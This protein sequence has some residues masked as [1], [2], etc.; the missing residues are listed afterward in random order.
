MAKPISKKLNPPSR[1]VSTQHAT[2][3]FSQLVQSN[4]A[5]WTIAVITF[6]GTILRAQLLQTP[7]HADELD[8]FLH[9]YPRGWLFTICVYYA[10]NNHIAYNLI[11][12]ALGSIFGPE[13]WVARL[14]AFVCGCLL[15]PL[16]ARVVRPLAGIRPAIYVS[17]LIAI[18]PLFINYSIYAR[19]YSLFMLLIVASIGQLHRLLQRPSRWTA[20]YLGVLW[21]MAAWTIPIAIHAV[22]FLLLCAIV[23]LLKKSTE[24]RRRLIRELTMTCVVTG[25]LTLLLYTPVLLVTGWRSLVADPATAPRAFGQLPNQAVEQ[26]SD[27]AW[28]FHRDLGPVGLATPLFLAIAGAVLARRQS[29]QI[30]A[31]AVCAIAAQIGWLIVQ[32]VCPF[33]RALMPLLWVLTALSAV[34]IAEIELRIR[35]ALRRTHPRETRTFAIAAVVLSSLII[36][37]S[38][39]KA[40]IN[41]D[42]PHDFHRV[43]QAVGNGQQHPRLFTNYADVGINYYLMKLQI[44]TLINQFK[45]PGEYLFLCRK[46]TEGLDLVSRTTPGLTPLLEIWRSRGGPPVNAAQFQEIGETPYYTLHR[47][48]LTQ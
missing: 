30:V 16:T 48:N 43:A 37:F 44:P 47:L 29:K 31:L 4:R 21:A 26:L 17:A 19:G 5:V 34:G 32:R 36:L 33:P 7:V 10:A 22:S 8:F 25:V 27:L 46:G 18:S 28:I 42:W 14:P 39:Q 11:L 23:Q 2:I 6:L 38:R 35:R 9:H 3:P 12:Q 41:G 20:I 24:T 45:G 13:L 40:G 1:S 15:I